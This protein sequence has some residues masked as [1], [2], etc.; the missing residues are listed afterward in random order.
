MPPIAKVPEGRSGRKSWRAGMGSRVG[1]GLFREL[2]VVRVRPGL[3]GR[4]R[5][6][7]QDRGHRGDAG[8]SLGDPGPDHRFAFRR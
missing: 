2:W 1:S 6:G 8:D 5:S 4:F 3:K 7:R